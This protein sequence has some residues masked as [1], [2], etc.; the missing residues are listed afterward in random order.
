MGTA[1][2]ALDKL[3][4]DTALRGASVGVVVFDILTGEVLESHQAEQRLC[5]ASV[6]KLATTMAA[7][8]LLGPE[9]TYTTTV[10]AQG[11]VK[12]R[13][14]QGHVVVMGSGDPSLGSRHM[15][16]SLSELLKEW[17]VAVRKAG[18][19]T[20]A[21][22]VMAY[23]GPFHGEAVPRTRTWEDMGN[24]FGTPVWGLNAVDNTY[25][26]EFSVPDEPGMPASVKQVRPQ[27]PQ[28]ELE[29]HVLSSTLRGDRAFIYGAPNDVHRVVRGTLPAGSKRYE[30]KGSLPNPARLLEA[31]FASALRAEGIAIVGKEI[32]I[33]SG[34]SELVIH[35]HTS[36]PLH[37]MVKHINAESDNLYADALLLRLGARVGNPSI[38]GGT[39][40]LDDYFKSICGRDLPFKAY[41]GSG[42]SRYT[43]IA[44]IQVMQMM[45]HAR[46]KP[47]LRKHVLD[48][49]PRA[50]KEGTLSILGKG[51]ALE[52]NFRGKSGSLD[53]VR[54]YAGFMNALTGREV[55][56]VLMVNNHN[57]TAGEIKK[58]IETYLLSVHLRY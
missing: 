37:R 43:A 17:S 18:I 19:D 22:R 25:F 15:G 33:Q 48:A 58:R 3:T 26:V 41:D 14:L 39:D 12:G 24:Y 4:T 34:S 27:V 23:Q 47:I 50:G 8:D 28:M 29:N 49:L 31:E 35:R 40:A 13:T 1:Q 45:M 6:F 5:P 38:E 52:G 57:L 21:G 42:L 16:P 10:V 46:Q 55:G 7:V 53:G 20:V 54:A 44:P 32:P 2:P 30:I 9:H 56:C 51:T 11:R 36:P